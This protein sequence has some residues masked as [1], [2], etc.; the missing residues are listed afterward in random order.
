MK[1]L[2]ILF[3]ALLFL[4]K[5][6]CQT[7]EAVLGKWTNEEKTQIVEVYKKDN[8][9]FAK[10]VKLNDTEAKYQFDVN[11]D[12]PN[13]KNRKLIGLDL[14]TNFTYDAYREQ[15]K[16]GR[17]YN[18]KNGNSYNG[19]IQV[20]GNELKLTGHYGFFFFLAKTQKWTRVLEK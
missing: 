6:F 18:F 3:S 2:L 15:W 12:D 9:Y 14:W 20:E 10:L 13:L 11:N 1:K 4:S 7:S 5:V 16:D 17:I 19:K 8:A